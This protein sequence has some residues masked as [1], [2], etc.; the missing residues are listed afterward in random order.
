M[1]G[2]CRLQPP[3]RG[4]PAGIALVQASQQYGA[5]HGVAGKAFTYSE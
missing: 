1:Q 3:G 5:V 2:T 4:C